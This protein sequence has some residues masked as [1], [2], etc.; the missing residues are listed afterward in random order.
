MRIIW[1]K[2]AIEDLSEIHA[3]I[4]AD[5]PRAAQ[6]V[7]SVL[8]K[9]TDSLIQFPNKGRTGHLHG[10]REIVVPSLPYIIVYH[11]ADDRIEIVRII[12]TSQQR[13]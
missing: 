5:N 8:V 9:L 1:S 2:A 10:T 4:N 12:H 6:R 11:L 7:A 13:G 3:F